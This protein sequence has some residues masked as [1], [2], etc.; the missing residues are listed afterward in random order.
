V[1]PGTGVTRLATQYS[2]RN[3][4]GGLRRIIIAVA[5]CVAED[6]SSRLAPA[7]SRAPAT[8]SDRD[9]AMN[10]RRIVALA[11]GAAGAVTAGGYAL[12]EHLDHDGSVAAPLGL[13]A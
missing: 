8:E 6:I 7:W 2:S 10:R 13:A 3:A 1:L 11:I 12:A 5:R 9:G 4:F